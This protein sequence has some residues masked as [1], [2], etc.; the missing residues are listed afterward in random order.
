MVNGFSAGVGI[1]NKK[2]LITGKDKVTKEKQ[3]STNLYEGRQ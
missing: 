3:N 2:H 1:V